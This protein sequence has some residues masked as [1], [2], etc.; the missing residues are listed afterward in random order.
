MRLY[1]IEAPGFPY[2]ANEEDKGMCLQTF[3][4]WK[5]NDNLKLQQLYRYLFKITQLC[6]TQQDDR[7]VL[8]FPEY[9]LSN[10]ILRNDKKHKKQ[11]SWPIWCLKDAPESNFKQFYFAKIEKWYLKMVTIHSWKWLCHNIDFLKL[12]ELL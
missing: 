9:W 1:I 5:D 10:S 6:N 4:R 7:V 2:S 12:I 3:V 8:L 11:Q